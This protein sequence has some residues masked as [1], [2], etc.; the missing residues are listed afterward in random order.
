MGL[1]SDVIVSNGSLKGQRTPVG[2]RNFQHSRSGTVVT[3]PNSVSFNAVQL[4]FING[5]WRSTVIGDNAGGGP[6]IGGTFIG[7][8]SGD[9]LVGDNGGDLL[10]AGAGNG[11]LTGSGGT[12][13]SLGLGTGAQIF[14]AA[15]ANVLVAAGWAIL[16]WPAAARPGCSAARG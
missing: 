11:T 5:A 12:G 8:G 4:G 7:G 13:A 2:F 14:D 1:A 6:V 3:G 10:V 15:G 9:L 16:W